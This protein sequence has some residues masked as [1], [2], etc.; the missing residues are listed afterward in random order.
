MASFRIPKA[1]QSGLAKLLALE[2]D[3]KQKLLSA[4]R[5]SS[6]AL[7][8]DL[9]SNRVS[10]ETSIPSDDVSSIIT[11]LIS[12]YSLQALLKLPITEVPEQV[13]EALIEIGDKE[14]G[15]TDDNRGQF[16]SYLGELL[17]TPALVVSSKVLDLRTEHEHPF[18]S[19]RVFTDLR[20]VFGETGNSPLATGIVH[21]LKLSYH[22]PDGIKEIYVA[23]DEDDIV[24]LRETL[25][26]ASA[27]SEGLKLVLREAKITHFE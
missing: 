13:C 10:A 4:L 2:E 19:A 15:L 23:M 3:S 18:C 21:M 5:D 27:R 26:A 12:L 9:L 8:P 25:D 22:D 17:E 16:A 24:D 1:H 6:T 11:T 20:P 14:I 7:N